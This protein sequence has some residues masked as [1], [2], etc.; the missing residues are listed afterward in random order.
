M[1]SPLDRLLGLMPGID[2]SRLRG[3]EQATAAIEAIG[4]NRG[5]TASKPRHRGKATKRQRQ[6]ASFKAS[7]DDT[8]A[9]WILPVCVESE[10]NRRD[11]WAQSKRRRDQQAAEVITAVEPYLNWVG[12]DARLRI[13]LTRLAPRELDSDNLIGGFKRI[14]DVIAWVANGRRMRWTTIHGVKQLRPAMGVDDDDPRF[15]WQ[16]GQ[17]R[18]PAYGVRIRVEMILDGWM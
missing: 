17:E 6:M 1:T 10:Q 5:A 2:R 12:R 8:G 4:G 18:S 16:Y 7:R 13:E 9:T 14:R 3:S 11:H 15:K